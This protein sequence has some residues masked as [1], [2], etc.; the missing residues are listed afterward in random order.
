MRTEV[1]HSIAPAEPCLGEDVGQPR[2]RRGE[3]AP[4][5]RCGCVRVGRRRQTIDHRPTVEGI[6][7]PSVQKTDQG[8]AAAAGG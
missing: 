2:R 7:Q 3:F 5:P 1:G 4:C 6:L 8:I